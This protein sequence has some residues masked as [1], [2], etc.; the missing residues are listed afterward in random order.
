MSIYTDIY[1]NV[2]FPLICTRGIFVFPNQEIVFDVGRSASIA[3][4]TAAKNLHD[5]FVVLLSQKDIMVEAVSVDN[6]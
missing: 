2:E 1:Q 3:A 4:I 5:S 6:M